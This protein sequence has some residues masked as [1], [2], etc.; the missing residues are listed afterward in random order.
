MASV[1]QSK[2]LHP[3]SISV[4]VLKNHVIQ[5]KLFLVQ[6]G[7]VLRTVTAYQTMLKTQTRRDMVVKMARS[8]GDGHTA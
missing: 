5:K 1:V 4:S 7:T 2:L 3:A 6:I 8:S